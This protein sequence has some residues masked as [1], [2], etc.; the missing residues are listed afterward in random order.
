M[1]KKN[2]KSFITLFFKLTGLFLLKYI[3]MFLI[4]IVFILNYIKVFFFNLKKNFILF[5]KD[6]NKLNFLV[7]NKLPNNI[8][9]LYINSTR[10]L[11]GISFFRLIMPVFFFKFY[12]SYCLENAETITILSTLFGFCYAIINIIFFLYSQK[13]VNSLSFE[14]KNLFF[15]STKNFVVFK[16]F[17]RIFLGFYGLVFTTFKALDMFIIST[18]N[19]FDKEGISYNGSLSKTWS[20]FRKGEISFSQF[21][22]DFLNPS[23]VAKKN[24]DFANLQIDLKNNEIENAKKVENFSIWDYFFKKK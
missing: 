12:N 2:Y 21:L 10:V 17:L 23:E 6:L 4:N 1:K 14:E 16:N 18:T 8:K 19:V 24:R 11:L 20:N 7:N 3:K 15:K 5:L 22:K 13:I 9:L